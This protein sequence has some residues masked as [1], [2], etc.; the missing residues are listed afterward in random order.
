MKFSLLG[1][2][3][4]LLFLSS[5]K[6]S[7]SGSGSAAAYMTFT[8]GS[9]WNYEQVNNAAVPPSTS[10]YTL[11]STNRDSTIDGVSFHVFS[12]SATGTSEYYSL[13]GGAYT[14]FQKLPDALGGTKVVN[15]YLKDNVEVNSTWAQTYNISY[16][17]LPLVVTA[18]NLL[19]EKGIS[20]N[21]KGKSYTGVIHVQT[22]ISIAGLP[23]TALTTDIHSYYAPKVGLIQS[24]NKV[25]LNYLGI[26]NTT[27]VTTNLVSSTVM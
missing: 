2:L 6:K 14:T 22:T 16:S 9:S 15:L 26:N 8:T 4:I 17:G 10:T 13:S 27:D 24:T 25:T 11:T 20:L 3:S 7:G 18:T 21:V 1:I 23:P 19:K 12:N 5:C